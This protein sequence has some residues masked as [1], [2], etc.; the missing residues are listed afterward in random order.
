MHKDAKFKV[1]KDE[2]DPNGDL[3]TRS[4]VQCLISSKNQYY[5]DY[6]TFERFWF[7]IWLLFVLQIRNNDSLCF[8]GWTHFLHIKEK[9]WII[10]WL[11]YWDLLVAFQLPSEERYVFEVNRICKTFFSVSCPQAPSDRY[12]FVEICRF[13]DQERGKIHI[14]KIDVSITKNWKIFRGKS[15]SFGWKRKNAETYYSEKS[16]WRFFSSTKKWPSCPKT[17]H[18]HAQ[19]LV[20]FLSFVVP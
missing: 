20:K 4:F 11:L 2:N 7:N 14:W 12:F 19:K 13:Y 18:H 5:S 6:E 16:F 10:W 3:S 9:I 8:W 1:L 15:L 17:S